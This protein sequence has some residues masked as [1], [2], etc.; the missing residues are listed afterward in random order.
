[1]ITD[2]NQIILIAWSL[3]LFYGGF[4]LGLKIRKDTKYE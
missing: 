2:W 4:L 1:M 3:G